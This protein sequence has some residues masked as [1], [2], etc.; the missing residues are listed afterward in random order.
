MGVEGKKSLGCFFF[1]SETR[2]SVINY[3]VLRSL[4]YTASVHRYVAYLSACPRG[5]QL[6]GESY[7]LQ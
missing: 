3:S 6:S 1:F 2:R 5:S 4:Q 7:E